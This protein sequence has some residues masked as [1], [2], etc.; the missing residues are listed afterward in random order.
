M[1]E[2]PELGSNKASCH[3]VRGRSDVIPGTF[4]LE[5]QLAIF[6]VK[7]QIANVAQ[8]CRPCGYLSQLLSYRCEV[9]AAIDN[10]ERNEHGCVPIKLYF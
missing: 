5:Q 10:K 9:K 7:G 6:S 1:K 2:A 3:L 8:L 4:P